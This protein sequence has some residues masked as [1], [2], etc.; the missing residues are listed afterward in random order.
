MIEESYSGM[1]YVMG[2]KYTTYR[3]IAEDCLKRI[4]KKKLIDTAELYPLY[5]GG[6]VDVDVKAEALK[7]KVTEEVVS[8]LL[9][10]Y[11]SRYADV[12]ALVKE[13]AALK[14]PLIFGQSPI[15]AEVVYAKRVEMACF[16]DDIIWRRLGLGYMNAKTEAL[17]KEIQHYMD[18]YN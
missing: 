18:K 16:A 11:G 12:L 2:G 5:G 13:D 14:K 10:T 17:S 7:Y 4:V 3:K 9:G 1:I 15:V 6:A 8:H